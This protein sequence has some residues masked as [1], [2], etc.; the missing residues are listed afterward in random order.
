MGLIWDRP[1][2]YPQSRLFG[3]RIGH[4]AGAADV[5]SEESTCH[6]KEMN[7]MGSRLFPS[8]CCETD[9]NQDRRR[10]RYSTQPGKSGTTPMIVR[11]SQ[12][13]PGHFAVLRSCLM[14]YLSQHQTASRQWLFRG[15]LSVGTHPG[16][17]AA[18]VWYKCCFVRIPLPPAHVP[19]R[20]P[21][22]AD[23]RDLG[24]PGDATEERVD[25]AGAL[26]SLLPRRL[27]AEVGVAMLELL[28]WCSPT[29]SV[30]QP[31]RVSVCRKE[32]GYKDLT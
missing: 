3:T 28:L 18:P 13:V 12:A 25:K 24:P 19:P 6:A 11:S 29:E 15:D 17:S 32:A 2:I 26:H 4:H 30:P 16:D 21:C 31:T 5:N 22:R 9:N 20:R 27:F 8:F 7:G 10:G 23:L 1:A 14:R